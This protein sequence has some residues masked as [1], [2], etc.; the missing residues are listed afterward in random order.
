MII[1]GGVF[2]VDPDQ[3]DAFI[4]GR[5]EAM[6]RSRSEPGCQEYVFAPDP[7]EPGRVILFERWESEEALKA[8][9]GVLRSAPRNEPAPDAPPAVRP[10]SASIVRYDVSGER[11]LG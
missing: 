10:T 7:L 1:I 9:L 5:L 4:Q 11:P 3:R 2:E 8:H 6:R